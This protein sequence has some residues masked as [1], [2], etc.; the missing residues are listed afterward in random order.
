MHC[1]LR[2]RCDA[3]ILA[4][5]W[6]ILGLAKRVAIFFV[7]QRVKEYKY[8]RSDKLSFQNHTLARV[9]D[10]PHLKKCQISYNEVPYLFSTRLPGL[11]CFVSYPSDC[12]SYPSAL[13]APPLP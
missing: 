6:L 3:K 12:I 9:W 2:R 1:A 4:K 10:F 13:L 8:K 5:I 7:Y 11:N